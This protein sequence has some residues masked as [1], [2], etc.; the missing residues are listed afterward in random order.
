[1]YGLT[2][3]LLTTGEGQKMGKSMGGAVWLDAEKTPPYEFYQYWR[4]VDDSVVIRNLKL[5]TFL[6]MEEI[7]EMSGWQGSQLNKAKEILAYEVTRTVH[8]REAAEGAREAARA[9]FGGG[10]DDGSMPCTSITAADFGGG[11][12]IIDL[13]S[14]CGL[15]PSRGEGRRLASQGG[16][17][18]NNQKVESHEH[19]VPLRE[20][21]EN[22]L[23][24]QKGKKVFHKVTLT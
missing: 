19:T 12:N 11:M 17:R 2:F 5:L 9:L 1:V 20:F 14:V 18:V 22:G 21:G 8:G 13:L 4:N 7:R 6:P 10:G 24:I 16:I 3:T 23:I 15:I